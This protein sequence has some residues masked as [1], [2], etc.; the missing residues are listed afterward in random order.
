VA[1][2]S[3]EFH[4]VRGLKPRFVSDPKPVFTSDPKSIFMSDPKPRSAGDPEPVFCDTGPMEG[5]LIG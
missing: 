2:K 1:P 3:A 5:I 4:R